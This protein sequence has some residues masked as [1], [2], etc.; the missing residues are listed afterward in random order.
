MRRLARST[1]V[2]LGLVLLVLPLAACQRVADTRTEFCQ[3]LRDVSTSATELKSA[4]IDQPMEQVRA[5]AERLQ[6]RRQ[7]LD[8]LARLT[9][10]PSVVKLDSAVDG[11]VQAVNEVAGN[12]LGPAVAKVNAAGDQVQ[13]A[14]TEV[15]DAA[16]AAK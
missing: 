8:R 13:Q 5:T 1:L 14:Y 12:T 4:K 7:N 3:A 10:A 16:C 15:Y 11:A 9:S 2:P 6:Q